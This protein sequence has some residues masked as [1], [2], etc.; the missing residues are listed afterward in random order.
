MSSN[1]LLIGAGDLGSAVGHR[2]AALG[3]GVTAVRRRGDLVPSPMRGVSADLTV[4]GPDLTGVDVDLLV[5]ALTTRPRTEEAYRATYVDGLAR[6]LDSLA[7]AGQT[8][9]RAVLV[10][11]TGVYGHPDPD[12]V[13]DEASPAVPA[14]GPAR[15][16]LEAEELF[17]GR[18]PGGTVLRLS[19][20]YRGESGR[21]VTQVREGR[22]DD[23]HRWT[24]RIHRDDAAAAVVHLLTREEPPEPLYVGTDDE[25]ALLGDVAAHVAAQLDVAPPEAADPDRG[26]G[27]RLSNARLR[28]SG[29]RP[30][31]PTYREGY[32]V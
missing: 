31:F 24:N 5:V 6:A 15:M 30:T 19:G 22:V 28:A 17:A 26:H 32:V 2:L 7:A 14:D 25:P 21:I 13:L 12:P 4:E 23:P 20:L 16:L 3:H 8:P 1:A 29:W 11:S 10:S 18:V 9:R 27:K